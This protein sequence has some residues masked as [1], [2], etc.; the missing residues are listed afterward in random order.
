MGV[1]R[2][3]VADIPGRRKVADYRVEE[4]LDALI[5]VGRSAGRRD[6]LHLDRSLAERSDDLFLGKGSRIL[7][8]LLHQ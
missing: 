2:F 5:L 7:E 1:R 8:V 4:E 6:D 3:G